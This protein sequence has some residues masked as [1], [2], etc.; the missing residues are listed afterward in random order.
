MKIKQNIVTHAYDQQF[1]ILIFCFAKIFYLYQFRRFFIELDLI[2]V[3]WPAAVYLSNWLSWYQL[4]E[5]IMS[6]K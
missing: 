4:K 1:R 5:P 3:A 2:K 6:F